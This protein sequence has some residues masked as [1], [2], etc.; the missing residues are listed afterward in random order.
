ME[1]VG[2]VTHLMFR[3]LSKVLVLLLL[4]PWNV[5]QGAFIQW[6]LPLQAVL[7]SLSTLVRP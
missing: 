1:V 2:G 3:A 7:L 6:Q 5:R 4:P